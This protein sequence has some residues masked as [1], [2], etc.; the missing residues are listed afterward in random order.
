[1]KKYIILF[2]VAFVISMGSVSVVVGI[3][4][5]ERRNLMDELF[6]INRACGS[7]CIDKFGFSKGA[8]NCQT[9]CRVDYDAAVAALPPETSTPDPEPSPVVSTPEDTTDYD[10]EAAQRQADH[11]ATMAKLQKSIDKSKAETAKIKERTAAITE[12]IEKIKDGEAERIDVPCSSL[13]D[14]SVREKITQVKDEYESTGDDFISY[15]ALTSNKKLYGVKMVDGELKCNGYREI[16]QEERQ[17]KQ[18]EADAERKRK[19]DNADAIKAENDLIGLEDDAYNDIQKRIENKEI[20]RKEVSCNSLT[21]ARVVE[22]I[23]RVKS[24]HAADGQNIARVGITSDKKIYFV[25]IVDDVLYCYGYRGAGVV[26]TVPV[27]RRISGTVKVDRGV[28]R[29]FRDGWIN[30]E[31]NGYEVRAGDTIKSDKDGII[32]IVSKDGLVQLSGDTVVKFIGLDFDPVAPRRVI[33][34]PLDA[35]WA[36]DRTSFKYPEVDNMAFWN[37]LYD[38]IIDFHKENPPKFLLTCGRAVAGDVKS[39]IKCPLDMIT[40]VEKGKTWFHKEIDSNDPPQLV[41][42]PTVSIFTSGTKFTVEVAEDGS[43]TVTTLDGSVIVTDLT[44]RKSV[45][46]STEEQFIVSAGLGKP[47]EN[48]RTV[49]S[50]SVDKWWSEELIQEQTQDTKYPIVPA[51]IIFIIISSVIYL[52]R[53]KLEKKG[54]KASWGKW[55]LILGIFGFLFSSAP[56]IGLL[57]SIGAIYFFKQ[58]KKIKSNKKAVAGLILG[59]IGMFVSLIALT[60]LII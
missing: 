2:L 25:Q 43:T 38:D 36:P 31:S 46:V 15:S 8:Q 60:V 51:I 5:E 58:Q 40:F 7:A 28:L 45:F 39:G 56:I 29:V 44:S 24:D 4:A 59:I 9:A 26:D 6:E 35:P 18:D 21:D 12:M 48:V 34:P 42:T 52:L 47:P 41:V 3:S 37:D 17:R 22:K 27:Y 57:P 19:Q 14:S 13:S 32:G 49:D 16:T 20:V 53:K 30:Q 10:A 55:S 23:N 50:E 11:E 1:M 33:N 54:K